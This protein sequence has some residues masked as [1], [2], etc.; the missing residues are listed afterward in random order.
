[1]KRELTRCT[2]RFQRRQRSLVEQLHRHQA[3]SRQLGQRLA[4]R[5]AVRD[6]IDT[7][8]L[9]RERD[10]DKDQIMFN[11]QMLLATLHDW[12]AQAYFAPDWRTLSLEKAT[13]MIYRKAGR[14]TWLDDCIEVMLE[15]YRY[16][17]QQRAMETTC[18]RFNAA[19]VRWRD[20]RLLRISVVPPG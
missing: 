10:L 11:W 2:E 9:C 4:Q 1:M 3:T 14:V 15:S 17:D 6:A 19:N 12:A 8:T 16:P 20:G 18:S 13:Q 5:I 7:Q